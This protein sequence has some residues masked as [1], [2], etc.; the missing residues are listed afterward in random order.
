MLRT[1]VTP[2]SDFLPSSA[3]TGEGM[4]HLAMA[5]CESPATRALETTAGLVFR[6]HPTP[7]L[8]EVF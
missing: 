5:N 3:K 2:G 6:I 8:A 1:L 7:N 4:P